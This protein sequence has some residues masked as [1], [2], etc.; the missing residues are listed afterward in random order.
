MDSIIANIII[1]LVAL[2]I[3]AA[4]GLTAYSIAHSMRVNKRP[5]VENGVPTRKIALGTAGLLVVVC[6][7]TLLAGSLTD[8]CIITALA[9]LCVASALVIYGRI[10]TLKRVRSVSPG[11]E[12]Q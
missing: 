10:Q 2:A 8:M 11:K 9:L 5:D 7:V 12:K 4:T 1:S 6:A 3:M